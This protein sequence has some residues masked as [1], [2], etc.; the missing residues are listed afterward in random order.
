MKD[1]KTTILGAILA[2]LIAVQPMISGEGY[3][4]DKKTVIQMVFAAVVAG[5]SY[6]AKDKTNEG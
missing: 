5:L 3:H 1:S 6:Y 2:A 4:W